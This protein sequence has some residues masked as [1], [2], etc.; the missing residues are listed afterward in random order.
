MKR[1]LLSL[2][3]AIVL[4][5]SVPDGIVSAEENTISKNGTYRA[6]EDITVYHTFGA[7]KV[8]AL[9]KIPSSY[10][11]DITSNDNDGE[12]YYISYNNVSGNALDFYI[13]PTAK[14]TAPLAT[15]TEAKTGLKIPLNLSAKSDNVTFY[16]YSDVGFQK[17]NIN[18]NST[19]LFL[20]GGY[21]KYDNIDC[22]LVLVEDTA[23]AENNGFG[24]ISRA[25]LETKDGVSLST[26]PIP[27][28]VNSVPKTP[29]DTKVDTP[30][31]P[32][33]NNIVRIILI[34]GIV[35]PALIIIVLLFKPNNP[36][37]KSSYDYNRNRGFDGGA[38]PYDSQR[39][40][41]DERD[42]YRNDRY[43]DRDRRDR[44]D[45]RDRYDRRRDD[46]YDDRRY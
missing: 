45:E 30:K 36:K 17:L 14:F 25:A 7:K 22:A 1:I 41:Y 8:V 9:F 16:K 20:I 18:K 15:E 28:H 34:V 38:S 40:R 27:L 31:D 37:N 29:S 4:L 26:Y 10:Y 43:D 3:L 35:V 23:T 12:I 19:S 2:I 32:E 42:Y 11:F 21:E 24:Y 6:T 33:D 5:L 13:Y 39:D 46:R 44:Y